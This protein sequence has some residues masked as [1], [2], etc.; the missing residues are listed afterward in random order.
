MPTSHTTIESRPHATQLLTALL[1]LPVAIESF[2]TKQ[3][4]FGSADTFERVSTE[5]SLS[6]GGVTGTGEDIA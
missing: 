4:R 5:V 1:E 3:L 6:G 2:D